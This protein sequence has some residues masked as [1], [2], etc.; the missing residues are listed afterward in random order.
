M[1]ITT[2]LDGFYTG[3][4]GIRQNYFSVHGEELG[5]DFFTKLAW[6]RCEHIQFQQ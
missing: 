3:K 1:E 4:I 6:I 5:S 2:S